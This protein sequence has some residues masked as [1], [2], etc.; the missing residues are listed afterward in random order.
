MDVAV[1]YTSAKNDPAAVLAAFAP[2]CDDVGGVVIG[3]A[4]HTVT[5]VGAMS[6]ASLAV[7]AIAP[8]LATPSTSS[9]S[10]SS[11]SARGGRRALA[12]RCTASK[13]TFVRV[14]VDE[15]AI[16]KHESFKRATLANAQAS[17][18]EVGNVR[19]DILRDANDDGSWTFVETYAD[20]DSNANHKTTAH[21]KAWQA[22]K[23]ET[24][25]IISV[26]NYAPVHP[27][28]EDWTYS[29]ATQASLEDE[30]EMGDGSVVH[31]YCRVEAKDVEA[32]R[33]ACVKN[34]SNSML[35]E[36]NLRFDVFQNVDDE[37]KFV[38][39]EVYATSAA[40]NAHKETA[41]YLEWR[42]AV[43]SMMAEP[44][45]AVKYRA[46]FPVSRQG[47]RAEDCEDSCDMEWGA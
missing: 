40:A 1:S 33:A 35:E 42:D 4:R 39:V 46:V 47:W 31:V 6:L 15:S 41:H 13:H 5:Q 45:A 29:N 2:A 3:I 14:K 9:A 30:D 43:A 26:E 37:T 23:A 32:F 8:R 11:S 10:P 34:A 38:L 21:S 17:I 18:G 27:S 16:D 36:D 12:V 24:N 44:R 7:N 25:L 19:F 22:M 20:A 28:D